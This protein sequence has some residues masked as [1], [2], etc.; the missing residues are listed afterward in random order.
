MDIFTMKQIFKKRV[1]PGSPLC[2]RIRAGSV[3]FLMLIFF[4]CG[5]I[6]LL[7]AEDSA[8]PFISGI[9]RAE[10]TGQPI[11][12]ALVRVSSPAIDMRSV[13]GPREGLYD[14]RTD[15]DGR[16]TIQVPK[17]EKISLNAFV[18]GYEEGAGMWMSGNW[19]FYNV[20]FPSGQEQE[21]NIKLRPALY[22]AGVVTDESGRPFSAAAVEGTIIGEN[23]T[24]YI[25]FDTTETN[26]RFEIFD[27]QIQPET[28]DG[29]TNAQGRLTF[30]NETKLTSIIENVYALNEL[31]RTNL[32]VTLSA[33]HE[34]KG[35]VTTA[36]GN[37]SVNTVIEALPTDKMAAQ[38]T[39]VTDGEGRFVIRGLP[40]GGISVCAHS[41]SFDQQVRKTAQLAGVD[42]ELNLPLEPVVFKDPPKPVTLLGMKLANVTTELQSV[43]NLDYATGVIILDPGINHLRLGIGELTQGECFW[44]VGERQIKNLRE[45]VTEILRIDAIAPPGDPN[46]GCHESIRVVY[47]YRNGAGT[48]TQRLKLTDAD[49]AELKSF[50]LATAL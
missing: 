35:T 40:D 37:P 30:R 6:S 25:A 32:H 14:G 38:R 19:R 16:F 10:D 49:R 11:A 24:S 27:F 8:P 20:P 43:Y 34:V 15:V 4:G 3:V 12:N 44:V 2:R 13:R 21:F 42:M 47:D 5:K 22:V 33:G 23:S 46:E 48:N 41:P 28:F 29:K 26:G 17:N 50:L 1:Q 7:M 45:L 39:G 36:D 9:V 18:P 31:E